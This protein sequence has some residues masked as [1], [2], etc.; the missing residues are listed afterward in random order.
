MTSGL[1]NT[2]PGGSGG[3][4]SRRGRQAKQVIGTLLLSWLGLFLHECYR[5]PASFG[6]T[7][8][9]TIPVLGVAIVLVGVWWW[10]PRARLIAP[11]LLAFGAL[12]FV[13]AIL[14]LWSF[15][16]SPFEADLRPLHIVTHILYGL[17]Q[18]P[19]IMVAARHAV[20]HRTQA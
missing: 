15:D 14:S 19:L 7:D 10:F 2:S 5:N 11:A 18:L 4:R 13:G 8:D 3:T 16:S 9:G 1:N 6:F 12:Q 17:L 20:R